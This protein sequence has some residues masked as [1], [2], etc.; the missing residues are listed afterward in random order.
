MSR[1]DF[2][3]LARASNAAD[4]TFSSSDA[5]SS[6]GEEAPDQPA[7][8]ENPVFSAYLQASGASADLAKIR[9]FLAS[10]R[11]S[12]FVS[13]LICLERIR[14]SDPSWSCISGCYDLFHLLCIQSWARQ[15]SSAPPSSSRPSLTVSTDWHCPKC[16]L[17]YPRSLIPR[18]YLC[19]CGKSQN[20]RPDPWITPH[21]CG[22][23]CDRLLR[24]GCGHHCL[25]LCHPGPC[26]P[27]PKLVTSFCYC[28]STQDVRRCGRKEFSCNRSCGK[29]LEC[30]IHRCPE[31][32]HVGACPPC[33]V[34]GIHRCSCGKEER[35]GE[36]RERLFQCD[37]NCDGVLTCGRHGC[38]RGCHS[39]SCGECLLQ[40]KR[41][42]PCG[43]RH[44][45]GVSCDVVVPT[46]GSSCDKLLSCKI[47]RC[48]ERCH[49]GACLEICRN[50][51][52]KFCRCGGLKKEVIRYVRKK[53]CVFKVS[54]DGD[55]L[56][57][58]PAARICF[59]RGNVRD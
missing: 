19:Y 17:N 52:S 28:G 2:P 7:T 9:T 32:C 1:E 48:S 6:G 20:P 18:T 4:A 42:C 34:K 14:P 43:K 46:C 29:R 10:S 59:V 25:L 45:E 24:E 35:E 5:S 51:I 16:R 44:Y 58:F 39:G 38:T 41:T 57:R 27:C 54:E 55:S 31:I 47:H 15:S 26:P 50:V 21:S 53:S 40:G 11:K 8:A 37:N 49:Q 3:A 30:D 36:C 13:C 56:F 22:E 23:I 12:S 33:R